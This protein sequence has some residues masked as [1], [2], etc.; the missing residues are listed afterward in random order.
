MDVSTISTLSAQ[1][2]TSTTSST[3]SAAGARQEETSSTLS[4][5]VAVGQAYSV[6]IDSAAQKASD[7]LKGLDQDQIDA[8][9]EGITKSYEIMIKTLTEHNAKLQGWLDE[10][11]GKLNFDGILADAYKFSIP[12]VATTPEEAEKALGEGGEW[13][14]DAVATRIFDMA[15]LIAGGDSDKLEKMRDAVMKGFEQAGLAFKEATGEE[16][17]PQITKDTYDELMKRFDDRQNEIKNGTTAAATD[18]GAAT[19]ASAAATAIVA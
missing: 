13:S 11:I 18:A 15:S 3:K 7:S 2:S 4:L 6:D 16:D 5:S 10:G 14:V 19:N 9:Q 17:M 12:E 8:L 1:I